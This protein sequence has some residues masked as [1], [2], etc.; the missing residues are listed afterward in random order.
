[1]DLLE[2]KIILATQQ[3]WDGFVFAAIKDRETDLCYAVMVQKDRTIIYSK[4][5]GTAD[6]ATRLMRQSHKSGRIPNHWVERE[7]EAP[8]SVTHPEGWGRFGT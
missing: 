1:M 2:G 8:S 4:P 6:D 5:L 3:T 7:P